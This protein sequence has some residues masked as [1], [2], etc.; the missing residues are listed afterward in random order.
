MMG[1][2][3]TLSDI[4]ASLISTPFLLNHGG[5]SGMRS[6]GLGSSLQ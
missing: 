1:V 4:L 5:N 2:K 3:Q 6:D